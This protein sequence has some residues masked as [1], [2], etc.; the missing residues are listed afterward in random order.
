VH[1]QLTLDISQALG[2]SLE[3][4]Q[5]LDSEGRALTTD[6]G[7]FLLVNIYGAA[8]VPASGRWLRCRAGGTWQCL[9]VA[10]CAMW[11]RGR[12]A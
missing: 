5:S 1:A 10:R 9:C 4:L 3:Q 8:A 11:Q 2:L 12:R 7:A 6:H